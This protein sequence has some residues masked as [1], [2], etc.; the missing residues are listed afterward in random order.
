M[1]KHKLIPELKI[2]SLSIVLGLTIWLMDCWV[3]AYFFH[4]G[5]LRDQILHPELFEIYLRGLILLLCIGFGLVVS[6]VVVKLRRSEEEKV[7]TILQLQNAHEEIKIL[8]GIL[9]ICASCKKI[10]NEEDSWEQ[11]EVYIRNHSEAEFSHGIC[12][13][14]IPRFSTP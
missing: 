7:K 3:D 1:E 2:F 14:C 13:D 8:R 6:K 10:R 11:P 4:E 5:T 12:P 9:P